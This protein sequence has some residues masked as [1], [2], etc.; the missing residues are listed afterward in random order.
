[1]LNRPLDE[2]GY[3]PFAPGGGFLLFC[4]VSK[5]YECA[6]NVVTTNLAFGEHTKGFCDAKITVTARVHASLRDFRNRQQKL[7]VQWQVVE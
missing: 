7:L 2:R 3:L 1:M 4:L 5:L 6:S